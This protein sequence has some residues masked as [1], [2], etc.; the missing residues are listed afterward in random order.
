MEDLNSLFN[1]IRDW[2]RHWRMYDEW[3]YSSFRGPKDPPR[4]PMPLNA[5]DFILKLS[6]KYSVTLE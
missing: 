3:Q 2:N 4:P 6:K 1:D 5:D